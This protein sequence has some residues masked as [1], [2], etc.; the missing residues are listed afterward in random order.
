MT[1]EEL[2]ELAIPILQITSIVLVPALA[3]YLKSEIRFNSS[4]V[5]EWTN[6]ELAK[7][8]ELVKREVA[9]MESRLSENEKEQSRIASGN[10]ILALKVQHIDEKISAVDRKQDFLLNKMEMQHDL[11]IK[12][13]AED[14]K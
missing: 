5:K 4:T 6:A 1:I 13:L 14:K 2:G 12:A 8:Y 10:E 11:I 7:V 3:Y 9:Y